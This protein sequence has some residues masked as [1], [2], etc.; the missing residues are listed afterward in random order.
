MKAA[1][2][3]TSMFFLLGR[4]PKGN[5]SSKKTQPFAFQPGPS[6]SSEV[7]VG[8]VP[9]GSDHPIATQTMTTT[10]TSDVDATV[11]QVRLCDRKIIRKQHGEKWDEDLGEMY[12]NVKLYSQSKSTTSGKK[13]IVFCRVPSQQQF[14]T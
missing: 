2:S 1:T 10:L 12:V 13:T 5:D 11:E 9:V 14:P 7:Y 4:F 3:S 8:E 6:P